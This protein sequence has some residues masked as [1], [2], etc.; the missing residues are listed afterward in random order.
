MTTYTYGANLGPAEV[1]RHMRGQVSAHELHTAGHKHA[2]PDKVH[3]ASTDV[4]NEFA[5]LTWPA[6]GL[7]GR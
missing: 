7:T 3:K 4:I 6:S 5:K 1:A 2:T